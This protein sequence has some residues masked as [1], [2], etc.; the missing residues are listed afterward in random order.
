MASAS[1]CLVY[2]IS[3]HFIVMNRTFLATSLY[4]ASSDI[5]IGQKTHYIAKTLNILK[6]YHYSHHNHCPKPL[7]LICYMVYCIPSTSVGVL[8]DTNVE[9]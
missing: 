6:I 9:G 3:H 1:S 8:G 4:K 2:F 7:F 5:V